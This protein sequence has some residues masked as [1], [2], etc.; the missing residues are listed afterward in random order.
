MK[1]DYILANPP[2]NDSDWSGN[3]LQSDSRWK[4][5]VPPVSN[6]NFA[7]VQHML[8]HLAPTGRAGIVL[9][10]GSLS[11]NTSNEGKIRQEFIENN[12][13]ECIISLPDKLFYST[14]IP[15]CLW[16]ISKAKKRDDIL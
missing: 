3:L 4:Y 10:N 11:S 1:A 2:F 5:G 15:A 7:W 8:F 14:Q 13:V 12:L 9:S 16:F 6:A